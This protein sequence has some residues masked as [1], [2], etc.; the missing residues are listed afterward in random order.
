MSLNLVMIGNLHCIALSHDDTQAQSDA[1]P[2]I[3]A[4]ALDMDVLAH[5]DCSNHENPMADDNLLS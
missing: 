1:L 5:R 2:P 4:S 3:E